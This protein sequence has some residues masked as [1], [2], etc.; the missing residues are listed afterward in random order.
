MYIPKKNKQKNFLKATD[1]KSRIRIRKVPRLCSLNFSYLKVNLIVSQLIVANV[2]R[3]QKGIQSFPVQHIFIATFTANDY[4]Q[5]SEIISP[6]CILHSSVKRIHE[7]N[8]R[9]GG[10]DRSSCL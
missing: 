9:G 3:P 4:Q 10:E 5:P 1:A 7:A 6:V 2:Q 8:I